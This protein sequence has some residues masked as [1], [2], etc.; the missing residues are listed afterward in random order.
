MAATLQLAD[1]IARADLATYLGRAG[2]IE[3][4]GVR[5]QQVAGA[6]VALW[7]PVLRPAGL[8]TDS[9][10]VIAVRALSARVTDAD[11]LDRLDGYF[12]AVVPLRGMLDRLAREP[13][14]DDEARSIPLPPE[15]LHEAWTGTRPPLGGWHRVTTLDAGALIRVADAGIAEIAQATGNELGQLLAER[16]R[17]DVWTR[18]VP[19]DAVA[20]EIADRDAPDRLPPAGAAFA[21]HALGFLRAGETAT[22][23]TAPGWWRLGFAAGQVLVRR[24][25]IPSAQ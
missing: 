10:L 23:T 5:I 20:S 14:N 18:I 17:T 2:R 19:D 24:R 1:A 16:V 3:D 7:V 15:R 11:E 6:G 25:N 12:D 13:A 21:A 22:L 9:P 8:L 4:S